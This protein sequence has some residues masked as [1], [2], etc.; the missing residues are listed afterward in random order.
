M[1]GQDSNCISQVYAHFFILIKF[2]KKE[3][4]NIPNL[5]LDFTKTMKTFHFTLLKQLEEIINTIPLTYIIAVYLNPSTRKLLSSHDVQKVKKF[6]IEE[7]QFKKIIPKEIKTSKIDQLWNS[8][9]SSEDDDYHPEFQSYE[10]KIVKKG[11]EYD[12]LEFWKLYSFELPYLAQVA[13]DYL[14]ISSSAGNIERLWSKGTLIVTPNRNQ[15]NPKTIEN[16]L[17]CIGNS[18]LFETVI[19]Q[20]IFPH[21]RKI[22]IEE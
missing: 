13:K 2:L 17:L 19:N 8:E 1:E 10:E 21:K 3:T 11:I 22:Q 16:L 4:S 12:P 20:M 14:C 7:Y 9:S 15:L 18:S 5:S 6:I